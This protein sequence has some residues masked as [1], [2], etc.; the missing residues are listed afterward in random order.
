MNRIAV[1]AW[2]LAVFAAP[3]AAQRTPAARASTAPA[4]ATAW[5]TSVSAGVTVSEEG[6]ALSIRTG[7]H[8][9]LW[10]GA[11]GP[12]AGSYVVRAGLRK[13]GGRRHEGYGILFGGRNLGTDSAQYSYVLVRGDGRVL[14]KK[15]D[16]SATPVVRDWTAASAVRPDDGDDQAENTLEVRVGPR[17]VVV[18]VNDVEVARVPAGALFT[19]GVAGLRVSHAMQLEVR[20]FTARE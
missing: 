7:P 17:E 2:V 1:T 10:P 9:D 13:I 19:S 15:R 5:R 11:A 12:L 16:G 8:V 18:R 14:V 3:A 20:G 6:G 4:T